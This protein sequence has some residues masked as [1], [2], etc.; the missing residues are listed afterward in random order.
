[1]IRIYM[2]LGIALVMLFSCGSFAGS[3]AFPIT[4]DEGL[5]YISLVYQAFNP[6][7][8]PTPTP[9]PEPTPTPV[10]TPRPEPSAK[11][12]ITID[13]KTTASASNPKVQVT[14]TLTYNN[15]GISGAAIYVSYSVDDGNNWENF[16]LVQTHAD[17]G[18]EAVWI[19]NATGNYLISA[20]WDGN[21]TLHW[22]NATANLATMPDL[23]GNQFSVV[24]NST[25]SNLA[26]NDAKQELSFNTNGTSSTTGYFHVCIPKTLVVDIQTVEVNV[27]GTP[28]TFTSKSHTDVWVIS[29]VYTQSQHAFTVKIPFMQTITPATIPWLAIVI[30]I[31]VLIAVLAIAVVIRRRRRTA[32]TVAA[33][34]KQDRP[35]Y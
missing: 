4:H 12:T 16:S 10:P 19:P 14:G 18:Y 1:M 7:P 5:A 28:V 32:A 9:P 2:L 33:I 24:S 15:T 26:Y 6:F 3:L 8:T 29:C 27:D 35:T 21:D 22:M 13:C 25:I 23:A 17:G 34:L 20:Q 30:V 31:V 11:P